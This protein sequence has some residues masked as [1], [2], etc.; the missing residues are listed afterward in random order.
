[1]FCASVVLPIFGR[2]ARTYRRPACMPSSR[3]SRSATPVRRPVMP[4]PVFA[5][6]ESWSYTRA[7][8][9]AT[10]SRSHGSLS[11][12]PPIRVCAVPM[13]SSAL[14]P[15]G[16][17]AASISSCPASIRARRLAVSATISA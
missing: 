5:A 14:R 7:M 12:M 9:G 17:Y 16:L 11:S 2:A 4:P 1:M 10:G 3:S 8:T 6:N 13:R 15:S